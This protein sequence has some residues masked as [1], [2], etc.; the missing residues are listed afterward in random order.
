MNKNHQFT[1]FILAVIVLVC[2][3]VRVSEPGNSNLDDKVVLEVKIKEFN[4]AFKKADI[5][6]LTELIADNYIHTN[7][8]SKPI[9]KEEWLKYL[10]GRKANIE[11]GKLVISNYEMEELQITVHKNSAIVTAKVKSSGLRVSEFFVNEYRITNLWIKDGEY[12][13]RAGF[14]DTKIK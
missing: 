2:S 14:H 9:G 10:K 6:R 7:G 12:W 11:S 1:V 8:N 4:E 13:K 5:D 3:C